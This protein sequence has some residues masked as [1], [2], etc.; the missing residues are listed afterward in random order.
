MVAASPYGRFNSSQYKGEDARSDATGE[1]RDEIIF[2]HLL[3]FQC[4]YS[5]GRTDKR[6]QI[7]AGDPN[8][9]SQAGTLE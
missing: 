2:M 1:S 4:L 6:I 3:G 7:T 8:K 9:S 5:P